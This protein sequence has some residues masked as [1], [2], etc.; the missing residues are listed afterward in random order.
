MQVFVDGMKVTEP[1]VTLA[2]LNA[3]DVE[4][5]EVYRGTAELPAEAAGNGC[6]AIM[7]WTRFTPN[8]LDKKKP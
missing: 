5:I 3:N 1:F 2:S 4:A 6:A 7:V 8:A